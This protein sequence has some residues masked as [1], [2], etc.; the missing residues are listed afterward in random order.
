MII[1]L[2][3]AVLLAA[4]LTG[5]GGDRKDGGGS[6]DEQVSTKVTHTFV[7]EVTSTTAKTVKNVKA[8]MDIT[9][10]GLKEENNAPHCRGGTR[11]RSPT[12]RR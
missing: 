4:A 1:R 10:D 9:D 3:V 5:C 12:T 11:S 6:G 2:A 7:F 8:G